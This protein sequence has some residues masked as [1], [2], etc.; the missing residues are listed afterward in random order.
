[1]EISEIYGSSIFNDT[2][3]RSRLPES[4][5]KSLK[6]TSRLGK[7]LDPEIAD[8]VA[9][10][11]KD[12]AISKG[13]THYTHWF[14]PLSNLSAGKHDSFLTFADK[15]KAKVV[16]EF[17]ASALVRGEPDAS[18]FPSG[19][20]RNTFEAR[21]YTAWDP[22]SPVFVRDGT[23][24]I[25]TAFC[26]YTGEAL[27]TKTPLLRSM[28][29]LNPQALRIL[30]AL[31]MQSSRVVMPTVGAEQEY[32]L[33]DR[34][35]YEK[36]LDLK[37]CGRTL[38]GA[39]PPKG[40]E[41]EDHYCGRIRLRVAEFMRDLDSQL[42]AL[43]IP[44]KT[45]HN[46][47]APA[48]HEMAPIFE[49]VNIA[50]DNNF[51]TMEMLRVT[52]KRHGLA[53]LLHEKPFEGVNGSGKHNNFSI[54]TDD[55][56][57]FL[58]P[59]KHPEENR[60]F[61]LTLCALIESVDSYA[62]LVR[63]AAASPGNDHRLGGFEAPP[64]I[65]SMFL[66]EDLTSILTSIAQGISPSARKQQNLHTQ[67]DI[68][69][70]LSKDDAD[71]NRT[72]PFAFTGNKFEFR[73]LGS[74][75]SIAFIN[76]VLTTAL[77]D[78][79]SRFADRLENCADL[80]MEIAHIIADTMKLHGRI[81]FNGNNYAPEWVEEAK[82]RGLP[83][84]SSTVDAIDSM[85][86]PKNMELFA[87][88]GV[89]TE[90]ECHA[91]YEISL[92]NAVKVVAIESETML[93]MLR[94]QIYPAV[95]TYVGTVASAMHEMEAIGVRSKSAKEH[96][97]KLTQLMDQI[98]EAGNTLENCCQ[99]AKTIPLVQRARYV[100][101][102]MRPC[103]TALREACDALEAVMPADIWPMPTYTDLLYRV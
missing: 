21:G 5:Y 44:S 36:R 61:L 96:L 56:I 17:T 22:T 73:V 84:L 32:F 30:K 97:L 98:A 66:G 58:N 76:M 60:L 57:N 72:S 71:R 14:Q 12:W 93:H 16:S 47:T 42:W 33:V 25:P 40:Q 92:E 13:A 43:G 45:K 65:I 53:C 29:A 64:A 7:P 88:H 10:A 87:R 102:K 11:M 82:R 95:V 51:L 68:L 26:A 55:G 20:L 46:E 34:A 75:Q 99:E 6:A 91:R 15:E 24:Y 37:L 63:L 85:I 4:V 86:A 28:Q 78:V 31:G 27:D 100:Q 52:A 35:Q 39:K 18:S 83:I 50:C 90:T 94:R 38:F 23:L 80:D 2:V 103:M 8:V 59:G 54:S 3:M 1:M 41:L 89:L 101:D 62:D 74:S 67:V 48:Q 9:T 19:G 77:A 69:P 49:T 70:N 79:F 81:I